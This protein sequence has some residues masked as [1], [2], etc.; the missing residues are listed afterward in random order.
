MPIHQC[1]R[2]CKGRLGS[3]VT[4]SQDGT[5]F[6][7]RWGFCEVRRKMGGSYGGVFRWCVSK[8]DGGAEIWQGFWEAVDI[9]AEIEEGMESNP[10]R[11]ESGIRKARDWHSFSYYNFLAYVLKSSSW[12]GSWGGKNSKIKFKLNFLGQRDSSVY[13]GLTLWP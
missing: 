3:D 13:E 2:A 4:L 8:K 9:L 7:R 10:G 11:L 12:A 5:V 1:R 6:L